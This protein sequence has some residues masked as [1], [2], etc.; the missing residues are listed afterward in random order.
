MLR[1][2]AR[3]LVRPSHRALSTTAPRRADPWLLPN[4]PEHVEKTTSPAN[5]PRPARLDRPG[6]PVE[7]MRARLVY[8]SRK[9]GTLESDLLLST[10]ARERLG[11]MGEGELKEFDRLMDEP[12]WDIYYWAT[13]KK[14]PPARWAESTILEELRVHAKNEGKVVRRM[15]DLQ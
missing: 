7:Q 5:A 12:D 10:F 2:A 15:P 4:T 11:G 9:R 1:L 8:Q 6:E 14:A 13:G 3:R